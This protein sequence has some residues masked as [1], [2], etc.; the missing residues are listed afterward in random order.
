MVLELPAT[1]GLS[2]PTWEAARTHWRLT[3]LLTSWKTASIAPRERFCYTTLTL[4]CE[5]LSTSH[6]G[7]EHS[8]TECSRLVRGLSVLAGLYQPH[9]CWV[10]SAKALPDGDQV[11]VRTVCSDR[12][13]TG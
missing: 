11:G 6:G 12:V 7:K 9:R 2:N 1:E 8:H 3:N 5:C 13:L 10:A 4:L